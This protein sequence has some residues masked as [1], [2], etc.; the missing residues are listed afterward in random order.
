MLIVG[1]LGGREGVLKLRLCPIDV[2]HCMKLVARMQSSK[3][4]CT[5]IH[6]MNRIIEYRLLG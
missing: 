4:S 6:T 5:G 2:T 1:M 3:A